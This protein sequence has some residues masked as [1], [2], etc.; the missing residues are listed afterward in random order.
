[1]RRI[2]PSP[3]PPGPEVLTLMESLRAVVSPFLKSLYCPSGSA[4]QHYW[5]HWC[6][7]TLAFVLASHTCSTSTAGALIG[8]LGHKNWAGI[9][10]KTLLG[11]LPIQVQAVAGN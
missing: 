4:G 9:L 8:D 7:N 11:T 6:L 5:R 2:H 1:M 3:L 10:G